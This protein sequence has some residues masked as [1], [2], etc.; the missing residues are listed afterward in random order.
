MILELIRYL[1]NGDYAISEVP[2]LHGHSGQSVNEYTNILMFLIMM[3]ES[4][5][6]QG[7]PKAIVFD[8]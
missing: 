4:Y 2:F 8:L 1:L 6:F 7:V 3:N 5:G